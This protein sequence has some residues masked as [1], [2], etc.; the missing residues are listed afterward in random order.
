VAQKRSKPGG[1]TRLTA[2]EAV[3]GGQSASSVAQTMG[4]ARQRVSD[5]VAKYKKG[6]P[7]A[8]RDHKKRGR[9]ALVSRVDLN[10]ILEHT[11]SNSPGGENRGPYLWQ[12]YSFSE[13]IT[14]KLG[15][16][17]SERHC[18]RLLRSVGIEPPSGGIEKFR[19]WT[20]I[21]VRDR[22]AAV[23]EGLQSR[24]KTYLV[25]YKPIPRRRKKESNLWLENGTLRLYL[26][27][28]TTRDIKFWFG[29]VDL[30]RGLSVFVGL[31]QRDAYMPIRAIID[32]KPF[33]TMK[34]LYSVCERNPNSIRIIITG[35]G[36]QNLTQTPRLLRRRRKAAPRK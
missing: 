11:A 23:S 10:A 32:A 15:V 28:S 9:K 14:S 34:S 12:L 2:V 5:W 16:V 19:Q 24:W 27:Q 29:P 26:A 33:R 31:L 8:L 18:R 35:K 25:G 13:L 1:R 30:D 17:Y 20:E 4:V 6:G 3:L 36:K 21:V 22:V 7:E